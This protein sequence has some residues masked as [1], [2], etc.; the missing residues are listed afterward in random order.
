MDYG[1]IYIAE[2]TEWDKYNRQIN[3][4]PDDFDAW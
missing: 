3:K 1:D 4:N 2:E